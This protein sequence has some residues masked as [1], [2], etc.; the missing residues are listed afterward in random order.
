MKTE[1]NKITAQEGMIFRRK[2][3]GALFGCELYLGYTYY[4]GD[5]LLQTPLLELPEHFEE[6]EKNTEYIE[7]LPVLKNG[8]IYAYGICIGQVENDD[9]D[10]LKTAIIKSR[11]TYDDQIAIILNKV[12]SKND[13]QKFNKMQA[14]RRYAAKVARKIQR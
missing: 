10:S 3:D 14:W 12:D 1:N 11:Y 6:V 4:L 7:L 9:Y 8:E 2:S 5:M 13:E